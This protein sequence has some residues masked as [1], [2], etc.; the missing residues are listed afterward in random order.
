MSLLGEGL[1]VEEAGEEK[2]SRRN[3]C[4]H[5]VSP[6]VHMLA[7]RHQRLHVT[8]LRAPLLSFSHP[9]TP[10]RGGRW[11]HLGLRDSLREYPFPEKE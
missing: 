5:F 11:H 9:S 6:C 10:I 8:A 2:W 1:G 4:L 7:F 3:P